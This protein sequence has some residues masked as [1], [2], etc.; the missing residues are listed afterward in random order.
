MPTHN[1]LLKL[2]KRLPTDHED[3]GNVTE[4]DRIASEFYADCSVGCKHFAD[5][6]G[7]LGADWGVCCNPNSPRAGLLTFEHQAGHGC[8]DNGSKPDGYD[9]WPDLWRMVAKKAK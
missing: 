8:F 3:F 9:S 5:L 6:D 2:V 4:D 1:D 7:P